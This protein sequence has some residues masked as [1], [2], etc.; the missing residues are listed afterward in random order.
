LAGSGKRNYT[1]VLHPDARVRTYALLN[2]VPMPFRE[3]SVMPSVSMNVST[4]GFKPSPSEDF[5]FVILV[6]KPVVDTL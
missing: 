1:S 6:T 2:L 3:L 5:A 4:D